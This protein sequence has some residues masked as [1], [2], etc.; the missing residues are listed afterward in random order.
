MTTSSSAAR[1]RKTPEECVD[2]ADGALGAAGHAVEDPELRSLIERF[3]RGELTFDEA[4][5]A[6]Q[7][8][9]DRSPSPERLSPED[10]G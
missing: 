8:H 3:S 6:G 4:Y 9:I 10:Q 2:F 7:H 5:E 1:R